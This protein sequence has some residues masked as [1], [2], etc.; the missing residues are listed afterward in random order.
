M[1]TATCRHHSATPSALS[2]I[3]HRSTL[4][5]TVMVLILPSS[6]SCLRK[7]LHSIQ[8]FVLQCVPPRRTVPSLIP[9]CCRATVQVWDKIVSCM[10]KRG[11]RPGLRETD[12]GMMDS[13]TLSTC[14]TPFSIPLTRESAS[15]LS[16]RFH[17][18]PPNHQSQVKLRPPSLYHKARRLH[19][20]PLQPL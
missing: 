7:E 2:S 6:R 15:R 8:L 10:I 17:P 12:T 3:L 18:R 9:T 19:H 13:I 20:H 1:S 16:S 14:H 5:W 11:T 4:R